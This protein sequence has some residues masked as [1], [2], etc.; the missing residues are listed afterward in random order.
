[1]VPFGKR[2]KTLPVVLGRHWVSFIQPPP[3]KS[4]IAEQVVRCLTRYLT[5]GPIS[6]LRIVAADTE[7]VTF[8][9]REGKQV[10]GER[11]QVPVTIPTLECAYPAGTVD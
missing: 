3:T 9:A 8:L 11:E 10:G 1:M 7:H 6:D 2:P 4:L 5:G